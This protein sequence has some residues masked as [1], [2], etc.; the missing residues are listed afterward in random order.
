[1]VRIRELNDAGIE[2]FK[3]YLAA[4]RETGESETSLPE[5]LSDETYTSLIPNKIEIE[6]GNFATKYKLP[7]IFMKKYQKLCRISGTG[8]SECGHGLQ[9]SISIY[10]VRLTRTGTGR[11]E[12]TPDIF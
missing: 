4:M 6:V 3:Y 9:Y 10:F 7:G 12:K 5:L 8:M 1:M 2:K 11:L